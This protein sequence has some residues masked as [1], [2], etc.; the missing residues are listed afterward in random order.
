M[1]SLKTVLGLKILEED[2]QVIQD[3]DE[4]MHLATYVISNDSRVRT[5]S[6]GRDEDWAIWVYHKDHVPINRKRR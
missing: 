3:H 1:S 4:I 6:K 2:R 5:E